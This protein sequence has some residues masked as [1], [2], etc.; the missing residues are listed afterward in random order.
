MYNI[1]EKKISGKKKFTMSFDLQKYSG[2]W[3]QVAR[4]NAFYEVGCD[5]SVAVY[6]AEKG[7]LGVTNYCYKN[8]ARAGIAGAPVIPG[9]PN[10]AAVFK[11]TGKAYP[12]P[13]PLVFDLRFDT[14]DKGEYKIL[15]TDYENISIVGDVNTQ[16]F[17]VL[18]RRSTITSSEKRLVEEILR[19][20]GFRNIEW[21]A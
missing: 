1:K 20:R 18:S 10:L 14:G 9:F 7:Y 12:T 4:N 8:G 3:F 6:T 15:F 21:T 16:Y 2:V 13:D 19:L 11:I 5:N 17:S